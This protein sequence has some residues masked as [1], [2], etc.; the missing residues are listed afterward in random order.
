[1]CYF[2]F[3]SR[4]YFFSTQLLL[5]I[6]V[7]DLNNPF[8]FRRIWAVDIQSILEI[9]QL[10]H[11]FLASDNTIRLSI[12]YPLF[13]LAQGLHGH[14]VSAFWFSFS[15]TDSREGIDSRAAL[16]V[17]DINVKHTN[18]IVCLIKS[19]FV[20]ALLIIMVFYKVWI[21]PNNCIFRA[22]F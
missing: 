21:Y 19:S 3:S 4:S 13:R 11:D 9:S 17:V 2:T 6:P 10:I 18:Q 12:Y 5:K 8:V 14:L 20:Y 7:F 16:L 22:L 15:I 1:M